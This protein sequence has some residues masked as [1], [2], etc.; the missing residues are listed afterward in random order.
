LKLSTHTAFCV[1]AFFF[2]PRF[3]FL[4]FL[5]LS[6]STVSSPPNLAFCFSQR[7]EFLRFPFYSCRCR[8]FLSPMINF[9][10]PV[11]GFFFFDVDVLDSRSLELVS[12][13]HLFDLRSPSSPRRR[14]FFFLPSFIPLFWEVYDWNSSTP[15]LQL[16]R[17]VPSFLQIC[18]APLRFFTFLLRK[19]PHVSPFTIFAFRGFFFSCLAPSQFSSSLF[20]VFDLRF[21][22][23]SRVFFSFF[24][25]SVRS[26]GVFAL[27]SLCSLRFSLSSFDL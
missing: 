24:F 18:L 13:I 21:P 27:L 22:S 20:Y 2:F 25:S 26:V 17:A 23:R 6:F 4:L 11:F 3:I 12:F 14:F 8:V 16:S 1:A 19:N 7:L 10:F 15:F 5:S 9:A